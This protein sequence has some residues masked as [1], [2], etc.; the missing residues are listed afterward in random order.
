M[1][2]GVDDGTYIVEDFVHYLALIQYLD[3]CH[4]SKLH[5]LFV[6]R[7]DQFWQSQGAEIDNTVA[8][9][10]CLLKDLQMFLLRTVRCL[11]LKLSVLQLTFCQ[12]KFILEFLRQPNDQ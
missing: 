3:N 7:F 1:I 10:G 11:T 2:F 12:I 4:V 8:T 5:E 6:G 9:D